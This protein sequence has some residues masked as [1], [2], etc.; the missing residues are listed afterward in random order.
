MDWI[1]LIFSFELFSPYLDFFL[2]VLFEKW[3]RST[4]AI[5]LFSKSTENVNKSCFINNLS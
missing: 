4:N 3:D 2:S 5:R 1:G